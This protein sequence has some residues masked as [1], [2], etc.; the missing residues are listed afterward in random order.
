M[1]NTYDA[2]VVLLFWV[3]LKLGTSLFNFE[4]YTIQHM[5]SKNSALVMWLIKESQNDIQCK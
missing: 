3:L 5:W 4:L 1:P 2:N